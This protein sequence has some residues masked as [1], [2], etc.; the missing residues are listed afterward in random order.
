MNR[1]RFEFNPSG[2]ET[3]LAIG[4]IDGQYIITWHSSLTK[5]VRGRLLAELFKWLDGERKFTLVAEREDKD[6]KT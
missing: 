5:A 4:V 6:V 2:D 3:A 1:L